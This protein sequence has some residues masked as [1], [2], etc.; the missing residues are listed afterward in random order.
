MHPLQSTLDLLHVIVDRLPPRFPRELGRY[1]MMRLG[2]LE[3]DQGVSR[4][5]LDRTVA[6]FGKYTWHY[7]RTWE[8]VYEREGKPEEERRFLELLPSTVRERVAGDT[9][10]FSPSSRGG[11]SGGAGA[12]VRLPAFEQ[13]TPEDR[14]IIEEALLRAR[15][16]AGDRLGARLLAGELP[17]YEEVALRW[18]RERLSIEEQL[19]AMRRIAREKPSLAEEIRR[20]VEDYELGL[21]GLMGREPTLAELRGQVQNYT[22]MA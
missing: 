8:E 6:E 19:L 15:R 12:I 13:Y 3:R 1:M 4:D 20:V 14:L 7:R 11:A 9:N 10:N 22:E 18:K 2:E 21:S 16:E 5:V 17:E